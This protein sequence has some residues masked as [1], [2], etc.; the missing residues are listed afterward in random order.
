MKRSRLASSHVL[1][2]YVH[3]VN[4]PLHTGDI[5]VPTGLKKLPEGAADAAAAVYGAGCSGTRTGDAVTA[6]AAA[7][8][9]GGVEACAVSQ[10]R[11]GWVRGGQIRLDPYT[12]LPLVLRSRG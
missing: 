12:T 1:R 7:A 4:K 11:G 6:A 5:P 3:R 10:S 9:R 2:I 8:R